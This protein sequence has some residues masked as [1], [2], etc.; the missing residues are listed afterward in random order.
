MSRPWISLPRPDGIRVLE[1]P[2]RHR[3][4]QCGDEYEALMVE[5]GW[6]YR[7]DCCCQDRICLDCERQ[8]E[9]DAQ[10]GREETHGGQNR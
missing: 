4:R 1:H 10:L 8:G 3:C 6:P 2:H 7:G 5:E 9:L